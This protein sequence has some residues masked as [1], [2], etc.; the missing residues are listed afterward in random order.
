MIITTKKGEEVLVDDDFNLEN[1]GWYVG[2]NGYARSDSPN[3]CEL[4]HRL[5]TRAPKGTFV[6]HINGNKLD[7]RR[8]NLRIVNQSI[9]SFNR[10]KLNNNNTTG[11]TGISMWKNEWS[12]R[13]AKYRVHIRVN[14]KYKTVGYFK[15]LE[16]A[17]T[18][19]QEAL[20]GVLCSTM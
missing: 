6:D 13:K 11:Y 8:E 1:T 14:Y 10:H 4:M 2:T 9:N 12:K 19:R 20:K 17:I 3:H 7:N 16:E 18:A 5:I 15:T